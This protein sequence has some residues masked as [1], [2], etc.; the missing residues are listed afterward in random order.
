MANIQFFKDGDLLN[1]Q[2]S[3][4]AIRLLTD[5]NE[6]CRFKADSLLVVSSDSNTPEFTHKF[7]TDI[8]V[9]ESYNKPLFESKSTWN[10][11]SS[12][13]T[14]GNSKTKHDVYPNQV[15]ILE[16]LRQVEG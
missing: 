5:A 12:R 6:K 14:R 2:Q 4:E 3:N 9:H 15:I 1:E 8:R 11:N 7:L 10:W 16:I 13:Q